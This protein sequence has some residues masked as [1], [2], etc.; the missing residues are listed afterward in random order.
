MKIDSDQLENHMNNKVKNCYLE[1]NKY[2]SFT[3]PLGIIRYDDKDT[4]HYGLE[5]IYILLSC[6]MDLLPYDIQKNHISSINI[7]KIACMDVFDI[8]ERIDIVLNEMIPF[9]IECICCKKVAEYLKSYCI[10]QSFD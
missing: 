1:L 2:L 3:D 4:V 6:V 5:S 8:E 10:D 7:Q 9:H